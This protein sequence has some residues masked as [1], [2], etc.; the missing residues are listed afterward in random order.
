LLHWRNAGIGVHALFPL[1]GLVACEVGQRRSTPTVQAIDPTAACPTC[2]V[3]LRR[4]ALLEPGD[5]GLSPREDASGRECM[6]SRRPNGHY[7][8]SGVVG[9]GVI[10]EFD[11]A[12]GYVRTLGRRGAGPGEL[13]TLARV[14]VSPGDTIVVIDDSNVRV[15]ILSPEGRFVRA[16]PLPSRFRSFAQLQAGDLVFYRTPAD[17][18]ESVFLRVTTT[19]EERRRFGGTTGVPLQIETGIVSPARNG[20]AWTASLWKYE[21]SRWSASDSLELTLVRTVEWFPPNAPYPDDAFVTRLPPPALAHIWEDDSGL[22]WAYTVRPDPRWTPGGSRKASPEW[23]ERTFDTRIEVI[24]PRRAR[25]IASGGH[26]GRLSMVCGSHL[27]YTVISTAD[28]DTRVEILE[29][30]L[31][32]RV[33]ANP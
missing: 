29:P 19:G 14:L 3:E 23:Y 32:G 13:G 26:S 28:G 24:D 5:R 33:P 7:L 27:M 15:Q 12:G 2:R 20:G 16:F 31:V 22:L 10:A 9:G 1:L 30:T 8:L 25:L 17:T 6:V 18:G 21:L 11:S 4:V